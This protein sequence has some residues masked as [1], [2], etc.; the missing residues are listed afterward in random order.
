MAIAAAAGTIS[1]S[2]LSLSFC[3][4]SVSFSVLE[5]HRA[6]R[7]RYENARGYF[8]VLLFSSSSFHHHSVVCGVGGFEKVAEAQWWGLLLFALG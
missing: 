8:F 4:F 6:R 7:R 3:S 5:E 1:V 2:E